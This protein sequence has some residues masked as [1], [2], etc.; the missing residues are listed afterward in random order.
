[1]ASKTLVTVICDLPHP[2]ETAA[3]ES[4]S[5]GIDGNAYQIDVC[6]KH[7]GELRAHITALIEHARRV[8]A[9]R[10]RRGRAGRGGTD[11]ERN[12][13]IREWAR[14]HGHTVNGR[15]RIPASARRE[16]QATH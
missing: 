1:M 4:L 16:Y 9:A 3:T 6:A 10:P 14:Q 7:A 12:G 11:R 15:G 2:R 13:E 8:S 5:F